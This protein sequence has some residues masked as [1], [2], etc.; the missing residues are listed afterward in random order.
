MLFCDVLA[1]GACRVTYTVVTTTRGTACEVT[2]SSGQLETKLVPACE[3]PRTVPSL[4]GDSSCRNRE[5]VEGTLLLL[6]P[7]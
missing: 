1:L 4:S 5:S 2:A 3:P 6:V 7:S